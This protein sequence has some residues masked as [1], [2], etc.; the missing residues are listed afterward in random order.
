[1]NVTKTQERRDV[2]TLPPNKALT[3]QSHSLVIE[4]SSSSHGKH[5]I[6]WFQITARLKAAC[7]SYAHVAPP[8]E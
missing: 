7:L 5:S 1:V 4:L 2:A 6:E 8:C 3:N